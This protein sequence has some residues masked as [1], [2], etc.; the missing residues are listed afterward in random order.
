MSEDLM[1]HYMKRCLGCYDAKYEERCIAFIDILGFKDTIYKMESDATLFDHIYRIV[2]ALDQESQ[3][4][5]EINIGSN[6]KIKIHPNEEIT[7]FSDC[8]VISDLPDSYFH[9]ILK[10]KS[11]SESLLLHGI[12]C[13]GA[14]TIGQI[15]HK[16]R[17]VFGSGLISAYEQENNLA[18]YPRI[19]IPEEFH[20]DLLS[21]GHETAAG[22]L[23]KD[24]DG[25]WFIDP[26]SP[27]ETSLGDAELYGYVNTKKAN[28]EAE[29][30]TTVR[31]HIE[32][33]LKRFKHQPQIYE[34]FKWI[35]NYLNR[36]ISLKNLSIPSI[37]L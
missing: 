5:D 33:G 6:M 9:V 14:I 35:A 21:H 3:M 36:K 25:Y 23:V 16:E 8:I 32:V 12:L 26:F 37:T 10:V 27:N 2:A 29:Y 34:K 17:I 28:P 22:L 20:T 7:F 18:V 13:R 24:I 30:F 11:I 19:I 1:E 15:C 31:H 4:K